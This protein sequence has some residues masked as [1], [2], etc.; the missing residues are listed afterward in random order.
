MGKTILITGGAR[1]GK[2]GIAETMALS[3]GSPALYIATATAGDGEMAAR[4]ATHQARR[5]AEWITHAEP[6]DLAGALK[7]TDGQGP[8]LVD[9]L[10]LWLS[11]VMFSGRDWRDETQALIGALHLQA[12]PVVLVT[13]ELGSGIV[14]DN[15][16]SREFR[17]AAGTINQDVAAMA[18]EVWLAV[19]G[20]P[21]KVK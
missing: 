14:P 1:S 21:M 16:L 6:L 10:T 5:G 3:M 8:R 18:D 9:C 4:I 12:S 2:S 15:R 19:C 17:D 13:N 7:R 20:L 11:N